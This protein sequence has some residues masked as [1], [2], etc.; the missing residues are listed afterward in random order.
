MK[1]RILRS[2]FMTVLINLFPAVGAFAYNLEILPAQG[3]FFSVKA[4]SEDGTAAYSLWDED[5]ESSGWILNINGDFIN[6]GESGWTRSYSE[7]DGIHKIEFSNRL[8]SFESE[9]TCSSDAQH[10]LLTCRFTN[11]SAEKLQFSPRL[12]L[13]TS[14]G[15]TTG[16]PFRLSDGTFISGETILEGTGIPDWLE[17][18]KS[19]DV[20]ALYVIT[21]GRIQ[22]TPRALIS[23]NWLRLKQSSGDF[24]IEEGRNFDNLPY[25]ENDSALMFLFGEKALNSGE[26]TGISLVLGVNPDE[27]VLEDFQQITRASVDKEVE[28]IRLREYTLKQRLREIS[29]VLDLLDNLLDNDESINTESI[30]D[31]EEKAAEL[32]KLRAEYENL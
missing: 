23:A 28:N 12:L 8:Y 11:N 26:D 9:M 29:T 17:S 21:K 2:L 3:A 31:I 6:P 14:L 4:L 19:S 5:S 13:D 10:I 22:D 15:E 16:L 25:S 32:E 24:S 30:S 7:S 27:P 1:G 18:M 20:P